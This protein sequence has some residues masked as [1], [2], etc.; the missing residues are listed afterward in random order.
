[1]RRAFL[2]FSVLALS[3]SSKNDD[4]PA[5]S[6]GA[7]KASFS[8]DADFATESGFWDF[9]WPS[10][11]RL[12]DKGTPLAG[13]FPDPLGKPLVQGLRVIAADR[14]GWGMMPTA[15]F[16]FDHA[17]G[18]RDP[19]T[20][21]PADLSSPILLVDVDPKSAERGALIPTVASTLAEDDYVPTGALGVA[22]R[23]GF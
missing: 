9:P 5:S 20:T 16:K 8:L 12:S 18:A 7:T 17:I 19:F 23:P 22:A 13:A 4:P 11:L 15:Y 6:S 1:M 3:C 10:D 14:R 2:V 21:I